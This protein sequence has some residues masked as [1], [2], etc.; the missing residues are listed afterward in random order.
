[1]AIA[2]DPWPHIIYC[3]RLVLN[4]NNVFWNIRKKIVETFHLPS[5]VLTLILKVRFNADIILLVL[6]CAL[7]H[8]F[9][10]FFHFSS[11]DPVLIFNQVMINTVT[12]HKIVFLIFICPF[13]NGKLHHSRATWK[14]ICEK[15]VV[16][17]S[18]SIFL[19]TLFT[20]FALHLHYFIFNIFFDK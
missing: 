19:H 6:Y 15:I 7:N 5:L 8:N 2:I 4:I 17:F 11:E 20:L 1:M 13:L 10:R 14:H 12:N 3:I 9:C 18:V 16:A